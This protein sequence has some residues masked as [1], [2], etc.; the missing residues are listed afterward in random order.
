MINLSPIRNGFIVSHRCGCTDAHFN[1]TWSGEP[2]KY[3]IYI[4][5]PHTVEDYEMN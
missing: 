5:I 1:E 4:H 2:Q 3:Y